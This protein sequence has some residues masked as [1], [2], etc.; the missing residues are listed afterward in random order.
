MDVDEIWLEIDRQREN[1]AALMAGFTETDWETPSLCPGWRV[2][3]VGA[4][5]TLA[6]MSPLAALGNLA[7]AGGS[8]NKMIRDTAVRQARIP[9]ERYPDLLRAMKGS[10][11]KAPGVTPVEPL[12]DTLVHASDM[13]VPLGRPR[14]LPVEAAAVCATRCWD[15]GFPFGA[16]RR[17][18]G[19]RLV[20]GDHD[21]SV[22][23]GQ[24]VE[25]SM[26]DLLLLV[27]GRHVVLPDLGG[28]GADLLR[29]RVTS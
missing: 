8:F 12:T 28:P 19:L 4:H 27:T 22:G 5:L 29:G 3:E 7:R 10:R 16:Q 24:V 21:W 1:L 26:Q 25:G 17:L 11:R 2:R 9:V 20:A 6:Q 13:L 23:S 14:T 18:T 15:M